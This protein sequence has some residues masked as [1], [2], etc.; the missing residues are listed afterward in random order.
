[1]KASMIASLPVLALAAATPLQ[2]EERQVP[3]VPNLNP[4]CLRG[5]AGIGTT[6]CVPD[7][8]TLTNPVS[9]LALATCP[10]GVIVAALVCIIRS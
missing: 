9:A 4:E 2:V 8:A 5:I 6:T 1:M 10:V 3:S 7:I